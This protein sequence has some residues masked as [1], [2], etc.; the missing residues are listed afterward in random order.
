[1]TVHSTSYNVLH[2]ALTMPKTVPLHVT[3]SMS[4]SLPMLPMVV[5]ILNLLD[6]N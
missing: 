4:L 6:S 2:V 3:V 1:M 5:M